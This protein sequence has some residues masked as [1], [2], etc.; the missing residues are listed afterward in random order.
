MDVRLI[1]ATNRD[2]EEMVRAGKFREDLYYRLNVFPIHN[3]PLRD[4][5]EDIPVLIEY[6]TKKYAKRQGKRISRINSAD[7]KRLSNYPFPGNIRELENIIE[8]SVV[9]CSSNTLHIEFSQSGRA[10]AGSGGI[11]APFLTFEDMQRK[12]IIDAL[13]RTGGRITGPEGAGVL[14]EVN[15]RTLV[16]KMRKL[17][18]EKHEYLL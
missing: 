17:G 14:L 15:D 4:R 10:V 8:R 5:P 16:S 11:G 2:L 6:F 18:I 13:K 12:H 9:L 1:A 7:I 3:L